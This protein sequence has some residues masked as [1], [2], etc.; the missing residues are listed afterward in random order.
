ML[1]VL[2]LAILWCCRNR[3]KHG[4]SQTI[5]PRPIV[6]TKRQ[7]DIDLEQARLL[8]KK[9]LIVKRMHDEYKAWLVKQ[10]TQQASNAAARR[11]ARNQKL[12]KVGIKFVAKKLFLHGLANV[13]FPG[14]GSLIVE[15]ISYF[16]PSDAW[17]AADAIDAAAVA[18]DVD[19]PVG[20]SILLG[21]VLSRIEADCLQ[22]WDALDL[23]TVDLAFSFDDPP[24]LTGMNGKG[25]PRLLFYVWSLSS[26]KIRGY[27]LI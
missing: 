21:L 22:D 5:V 18:G 13:L 7:V 24:D 16:D 26:R 2:I 27:W 19:I 11:Q 25:F 20:P 9:Y 15:G 3:K 1:I 14:G 6:K 10:R 23:D 12:V 8:R 4:H 17:D